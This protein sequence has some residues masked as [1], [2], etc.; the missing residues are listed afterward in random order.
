MFLEFWVMLLPQSGNSVEH[1][2]QEACTGLQ[3]GEAKPSSVCGV[4]GG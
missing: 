2:I 4:A 1:G 3:A